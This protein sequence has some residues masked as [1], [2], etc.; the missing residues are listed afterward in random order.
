[1]SS[2]LVPGKELR[3]FWVEITGS[4]GRVSF[5]FFKGASSCDLDIERLDD[6]SSSESDA[7][8]SMLGNFVQAIHGRES[9]S[10]AGIDGV[11]ALEVF[12]AARKACGSENVVT[13]L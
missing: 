3:D 1:M 6:S 12:E 9:I 13:L 8:Y 5:N 7:V 4:Q 2:F 11:K 10:A